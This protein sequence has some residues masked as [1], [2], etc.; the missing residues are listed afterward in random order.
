MARP[1]TRRSLVRPVSV[2][3]FSL[4][5]LL[6]RLGRRRTR[7]GT[8]SVSGVVV[9]EV[10]AAIAGARVT[11]ERRGGA[12]V[13]TTT[14]DAAGAFALRGLAP[15]TYSV[16]VEMNLFAPF[17]ERVTVP[18]SGS[19]APLRVVLKAGGFAE[20]V[21][22]TGPARRDPRSRRR[23]RR[24]RSSTPPTSSDRSRPI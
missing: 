17:A 6:A 13:Q 3:L 23:R 19:A 5:V 21:V 15:G 7:A 18:A 8:R 4:R 14:S 11:V 12:V 22:V 10:G 1:V 16:L 2:V 24:S 20:S 9:D